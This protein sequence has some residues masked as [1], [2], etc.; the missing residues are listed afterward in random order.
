MERAYSKGVS[1]TVD[2]G[3]HRFVLPETQA[4]LDRFRAEVGALLSHGRDAGARS[5]LIVAEFDAPYT[6]PDRAGGPTDAVYLLERID[7]PGDVE[8][9]IDA[10][11]EAASSDAGEP[12]RAW[13]GVACCPDDSTR[14]DALLA[15]AFALMN[16]ERRR[17]QPR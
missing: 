1:E 4:D 13:F 12:V 8:R 5:A 6:L 17:T 7:D 2:D 11:G 10:L 3:L 15:R 16:R 9:V 14:P